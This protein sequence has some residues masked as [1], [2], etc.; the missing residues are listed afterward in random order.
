MRIEL[1]CPGC[2]GRFTAP[3]DAPASDI[4]DRMTEDGPWYALAEGETF[5]EMILE[6]LA[7][8]GMIRCPE[9]GEAVVVRVAGA[10]RQ[11]LALSSSC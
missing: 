10:E 5:E 11:A 3:A 7:W 9:C 6:A 4:L 8:R 2:A 1:C